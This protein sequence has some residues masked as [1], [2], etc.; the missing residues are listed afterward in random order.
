MVQRR[1]WFVPPTYNRRAL[2][3]AGVL[4]QTLALTPIG[5]TSASGM[6]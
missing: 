4:A 5:R 6:A 1:L 3:A 2:L